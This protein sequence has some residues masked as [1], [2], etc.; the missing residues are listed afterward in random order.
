MNWNEQQQFNLV[1]RFEPKCCITNP[2]KK[3]ARITRYVPPGAIRAMQIANPVGTPG[4]CGTI[5]INKDIQTCLCRVRTGTIPAVNPAP[6]PTLQVIVAGGQDRLGLDGGNTLFY[7]IDDGVTWNVTLGTRFL[8]FGYDIARGGTNTWIAVGGDTFLPGGNTILRSTDGITWVPAGATRFVSNGFGVAWGNNLWIAV[9]NNPAILYSTNDG[10]TWTNAGV[11]GFG[12]QGGSIAFGN[13]RWVAGAVGLV[14]SLNGL[15]WSAC[16]GTTFAGGSG[17]LGIAYDGTG[18]WVAVGSDQLSPT[19]PTVTIVTSTDGV[20]W[21]PA[22]SGGF[23]GDAGG[24]VDYSPQQGR[25]VAGGYGTPSILVSSDGQNWSGAGVT[26]APSAI[27]SILW[28]G[29]RW[30]AVG[31]TAPKTICW[32]LDGYTWV[33]ASGTIPLL[34]GYG[35]GR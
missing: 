22:T 19:P 15:A 11:T 23:V 4:C 8:G 10:L 9:G 16:T 27:T 24:G 26:G 29:T 14:T 31:G 18:R 21:V 13:N 2:R 5:V 7:S 32:S 34:L 12:A 1:T 28:T 30:I 17:A 25:W 3:P 6:P 35:S 20:N 33:Q